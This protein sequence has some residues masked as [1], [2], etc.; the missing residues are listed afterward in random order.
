MK[1]TGLFL[2][3]LLKEREGLLYMTISSSPE[4]HDDT[5]ESFLTPNSNFALALLRSLYESL[6]HYAIVLENGEEKH[7][8]EI[9]CPHLS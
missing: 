6:E 2:E 1:D 5:L 7:W 3:S 8:R 4:I 9:K